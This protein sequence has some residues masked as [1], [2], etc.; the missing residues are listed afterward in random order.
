MSQKTVDH[1]AYAAALGVWSGCPCFF[2][3]QVLELMH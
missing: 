3:V 1:L 2:I